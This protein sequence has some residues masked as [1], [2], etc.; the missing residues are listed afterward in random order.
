MVCGVGLLKQTPK[1]HIF[2]NAGLHA[3]NK[4]TIIGSNN[5]P[6]GF[7]KVFLMR[8]LNN[9]LMSTRIT[10]LIMI[11]IFIWALKNYEE[12]DLRPYLDLRTI[13]F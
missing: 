6:L 4:I 7:F 2:K 13:S 5:N 1:Q 8:L 11:K 3:Q 10:V 9:P 12:S